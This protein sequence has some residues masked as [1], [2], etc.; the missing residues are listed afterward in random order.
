MLRRHFRGD[1][2]AEVEH[3][4]IARPVGS[5]DTRHLG[6]DGCRL[7]MQHGGVHVAL[8]GDL[9]AHALAR[10]ADVAGPVQ[11]QGLGA[12]VG[13]GFQPQATALG[14]QDHRHAAP[15]VFADQ[16]VDDLLHVAQGELLVGRRGQ[17]A[18]PG[19][20]DL[21]GLRA[22]LDLPVE[23]DGDRA[24][25]LVE[26]RVHGLRV[27]VE[28]R[29]GLAEVAA[30]AALDH[31]GGQGPGAAGEADQR[32][33]AVQLAADGAHGIHHVAQVLLGVGNRQ[34]LDIGHA[35]H[36]LLEARTLAGFEVQALAHGIGDGEDV[37]EEDRGVDLRVAIQR[38][39]GHFAGQ[40]GVLHQADE[41]TGLGAGGAIFRQ[42]TT[43]LAHHP[44][45]RDVDG[46]LE[47][48]AQETVVLQGGHRQGSWKIGREA[49]QREYAM[50]AR[51]RPPSSG[52]APGSQAPARLGA[53]K[54]RAFSQTTKQ[55][56]RRVPC[57]LSIATICPSS[58]RAPIRRPGSRGCLRRR[59]GLRRSPS[60]PGRNR[61]PCRHRRRS[62]GCW[63]GA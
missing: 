41:V 30:G 59:C 48:G 42:V 14:E 46:L 53:E 44:H 19:V 10:A 11:A 57:L 38:L 52:R 63:S 21:H 49:L 24:G 37:G 28:H 12:G 4:A 32:H 6:T 31:V 1:A 22:G 43:G 60:P 61:G 25:Q 16:A 7:G 2:V 17:R 26:Q 40:L 47:Q 9:I 50:A 13:H 35:R 20:E 54:V 3:L 23:V 15:V 51:R 34:G 58:R 8:Q 36:H 45:G 29:L 39:D 33:A 56:A 27:V 55:K 5:E 18:A 62:S